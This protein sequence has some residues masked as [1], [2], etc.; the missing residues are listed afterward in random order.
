[1]ARVAATDFKA[2]CL[3]LMDLVAERHE[4]YVITKRGRPVAT[5]GPV[6]G[7]RRSTLF[8]CM[9]DR[10][11]ISGDLLRPATDNWE[12]VSE[13]DGLDSPRSAR[14]SVRPPRRKPRR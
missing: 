13:W 8:G 7:Q 3:E 1:V 12:V 11:E 14:K 4:S 6:A 2:R 9:R 5:L 10:A